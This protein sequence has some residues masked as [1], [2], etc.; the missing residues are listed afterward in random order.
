[1]KLKIRFEIKKIFLIFF[2]TV[3][4]A[5]AYSQN[6]YFE[7]P[8]LL[9]KESA[10][11]P[12]VVA[13]N[14]RNYLFFEEVRSS[15]LYV[16]YISKTSLAEEW[17]EKKTVA[18]PFDYSGEVPDIYTAAV[19]DDGTLSVAV[20][21]SQYE[22]GVYTST[23]GG[24]NFDSCVLS[25]PEQKIVAPRIFKT[26]KNSFVLFASLSEGSKFSIAYSTSADGKKWSRFERFAPAADLDNSFSPYLCPVDGGDLVVF[27]S[28]F[29]VPDKPKTFQLY[30]TFSGD[31]FK[32]FSA[33]VLLTD[34]SSTLS[35][36]LNSFIEYSNQSPVLYS[37]NGEIWCAWERSAVRSETTYISLVKINSD[38]KI[39]DKARVR[40]YSDL[41]DSH[42]PQFFNFDGTDT[43]LWFDNNNG[44]YTA[45]KTGQ[46]FGSERLVKNSSGAGFVYPVIFSSKNEISYIWQKQSESP[47]IFIVNQDKYSRP[48]ELTAVNFKK[49]K[50][51]TQEK[52]R[53]RLTIPRDTNGIAAYSYSFSTNPFAEPSTADADMIVERNLEAG[54]SYVI[55]ETAP[56]DGEYYFKAKVLDIAGNWSESAQIKYYR[57]LTPPQ[58]CEIPSVKKDENGFVQSNT[59]SISWKKNEDDSDVAGYSWSLTKVGDLDSRFKNLGEKSD[60]LT[61]E[62]KAQLSKYIE[63]IEANREHFVKKGGKVPRSVMTSKTQLSFNNQRN[64]IYVFSVRAVDEV[65]NAGAVTS[66]ILILNK[67]KPRTVLSG[68]RTKKDD[69]GALEISIYGQDFNYEGVVD[70]IQIE[71]AGD[72]DFKKTFY[73]DHRDFKIA[74]SNLITGLKLEDLEEGS[75]SVKLHH[76]AR[77]FAYVQKKG[78]ERFT[79]D[80]SGTVKIEHPFV[81][82]PEWTAQS[83]GKYSIQVVDVLFACLLVLCVLAVIFAGAGIIGTVKESVL[84]QSEVN[85]LLTGEIMPLD[86]KLKAEK[87]K[88]K[89]TSLKFKLVGFTVLLVLAIVLMVSVSLGRRM[90]TTQ[91]QTLVESMQEQ[92]VVLMEGMAN[93]VQNAMNDAVEG[94]SSVGLIDLVRQADTFSPAIFATVMGRSSSASKDKDSPLDY[95]WASTEKSASVSTK[96]DTA[97]PLAGKSRFKADSVEAKISAECA[98]LE[99]TAHEKID[100]ILAEI[101]RKYSAEKKEEYT[102]ILRSLSRTNARAF[103]EFNEDTLESGSFVYTFYYPVFYKNSGDDSLLHAVLV[104]EV[105]AEELVTSLQKSKAAI[106]AIA[107]VVALIA[108]ALGIV[109]AW[110]LASLIVEPIKKLM[111]H[112]KIITETKD[113]KQL[114]SFEINIKTRDEIGTL[115]DAVNEMTAGLVRAA[116]EEE[117]A[118]EQEKMSLDAKAV[119]QTFLPLAASE[120]GG[121]QTTAHE[122]E[123]NLE[124]FGY[125]EGADAVSGDYFDY[126]KLDERFWAIVKCDVSGHGVPA[127]LIMTVV[128]TLF[129]KY[130]EKWT[131]KTHGTSLDRLAVQINDFIESLGVKGKFATLLLCLFDSDTGDAWL[132]NAGDNIVHTFSSR[133]RTINTLTLHEAPA[134][135]PLPSFMVE[136]KGGFKVEKTHLEKG[137][138]LFL[139]TDGI[140]EATRFFRDKDF[141]VVP[142]SEEGIEEGELHGN[143][144]KGQTSEQMEFERVKEILEAVLNRK[145]WTLKKYHSPEEEELIFDFTKLEGT[146]GEAITALAAVEK[147]FRMYKTP[148]A[149]GS[150]VRGE[151]GEVQVYGDA[152]RVDRKIDLF[153]KNTFNRYDYYC[154][155]V[156]DMEESNYVYYTG[157]NEDPQADDLTLLALTKL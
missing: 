42:R 48:P 27:Q 17:S 84:I 116:E 53:I 120:R 37:K 130:F 33:P 92:V 126:K 155:S 11:F 59:F 55:T 145:R 67:Y 4:C 112:V 63:E 157:V 80:E 154:S 100:S 74:S 134:A 65:G 103:P 108:L 30:T 101:A 39:S 19:L 68:L 132:C 83:T 87:L 73:Y 5:G 148:E 77:G 13:A 47:Q 140:E 58:L 114:K 127:A 115:G 89:Q 66:E 117:K 23:D 71:K 43:L 79:V 38:G 85:S 24:E 10:Q 99:Q 106:I 121:K 54:K 144:K 26:K 70:R 124:L 102:S 153:L 91:R 82:T 135:G 113:K 97:E 133:T 119:Q 147:V 69:F 20:T 139:Y 78:A 52:I 32:T 131:L 142:C 45:Q 110:V 62:K 2:A 56:V 8:E 94:G 41:K 93:S 16:E 122:K 129:R 143:H 9:I 152:V 18:G 36:R 75:Y 123:K 25:M 76:S 151:T 111:S 34:D 81:L 90:I 149:T 14:N 6:L 128:A 15:K 50:R 156:T 137:D 7:S 57:D 72:T 109:G 104:L 96:L 141:K 146:S 46:N 88:K 44:A 136:M 95:F 21:R 150:V 51:S 29:S 31:G 125:Y 64:G 35:R 86:K 28:H 22:I 3:F 118:L 107:S 61:E 1:M 49:D 105:S 138:V 12:V 60:S 40:E 98:P